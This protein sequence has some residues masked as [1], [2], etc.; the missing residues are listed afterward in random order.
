MKTW[1]RGWTVRRDTLAFSTFFLLSQVFS[2][3]RPSSWTWTMIML[4][5]WRKCNFRIKFK[6]AVSNSIEIHEA[7]RLLD[8]IYLEAVEQAQF[9]FC[10]HAR[11]TLLCGVMTHML[12]LA[13]LGPCHWSCWPTWGVG[14]CLLLGDDCWWIMDIF[15][16]IRR[17]SKFCPYIFL[18]LFFFLYVIVIYYWDDMTPSAFTKFSFLCDQHLIQCEN[19]LV[20]KRVYV[21]KRLQ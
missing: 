18:Y 20:L 13:T 9:V 12:E 5:R 19:K 16:G 2:N 21:P 3:V 17:P 8:A 14:E 7:S 15:K 1:A 6:M 10:Y 4:T 11:L